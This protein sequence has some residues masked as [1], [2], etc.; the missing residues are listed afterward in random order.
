MHNVDDGVEVKLSMTWVPGSMRHI[1][2]KIAEHCRLLRLSSACEN[3][4][5]RDVVVPAD[6]QQCCGRILCCI[7]LQYF[8]IF[9][10]MSHL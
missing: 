2:P 10:F 5:I 9:L 8:I 7:F 6:T 4:G 3:G 1:C